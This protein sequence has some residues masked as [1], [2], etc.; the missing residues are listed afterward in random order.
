MS[1]G[2][3]LELQKAV[4]T[5]LA[6]DSSTT[7]L[8]SDRIYD[9]APTP[10]S[11]PFIRF[12]GI[13]PRAADTDGS[14][15]AE[16]TLFIEAFSQTTGRVE[17]TRIVEAVRTALHRQETNVSLS[18]F[19]LIDLRCENYMVE[20]NTDDRGHKGSILFNANIQTA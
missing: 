10:V 4:R 5:R 8:V 9:E 20:K 17:A 15:G 6:A 11:Y 18:G 1:N 12:G 3:A 19:H 7:A 2:F 16:V 14:I 13:V